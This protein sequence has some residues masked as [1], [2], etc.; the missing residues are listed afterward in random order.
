MI[1]RVAL[2][3]CDRCRFVFESDY[4]RARDIVVQATHEGWLVGE[5]DLCPDCAIEKLARLT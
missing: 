2:L 5:G 4:I 3:R 1:V